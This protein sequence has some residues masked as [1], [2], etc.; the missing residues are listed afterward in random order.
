MSHTMFKGSKVALEGHLPA[1]GSKAPPFRLVRRDLSEV[2]LD[3][4]AGH[5]VVMNIFPSLD[6][7]VCAASVRR[8]HQLLADHPEIKVLNIS[9]DLPFAMGRF[10]SAESMPT[11]E[12]LSGVRFHNFGRDYGLEIKEGPL[13]GLF[14]RATIILDE[15]GQVLY[16]DLVPEITQEPDYNKVAAALGIQLPALHQAEKG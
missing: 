3:N 1:I 6:T 13:Q 9:M 8:F 15:E 10:C 12:T 11:A 7:T 16:L 4:F 5:K 14:A 2:T